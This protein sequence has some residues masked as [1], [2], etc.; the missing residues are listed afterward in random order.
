MSSAVRRDRNSFQSVLPSL[1]DGELDFLVAETD[2]SETL[3]R[4][5]DRLRGSER[6]SADGPARGPSEDDGRGKEGEERTRSAQRNRRGA[7][8]GRDKRLDAPLAILTVLVEGG[9]EERGESDVS[10]TDGSP[11]AR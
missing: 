6:G 7:T 5:R 11:R 2:R 9:C 3:S 1:L 8:G 10:G 4:A